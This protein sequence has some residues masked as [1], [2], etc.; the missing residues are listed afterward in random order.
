MKAQFAGE[1]LPLEL[2]ILQM[3]TKIDRFGGNQFRGLEEEIKTDAWAQTVRFYTHR[4][5]RYEFWKVFCCLRTR[6]GL[7]GCSAGG[8][9]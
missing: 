6:N 7:S 5:G 1:D 3:A 9:R 8:C 4:R 2:G